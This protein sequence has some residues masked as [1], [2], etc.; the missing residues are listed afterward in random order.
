MASQKHL[1]YVHAGRIRSEV[2][3]GS[4]FMLKVDSYL[5]YKPAGGIQAFHICKRVVNRFHKSLSVVVQLPIGA[6]CHLSCS[7]EQVD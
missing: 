4:R 2:Y 1:Q 7:V 5:Q 3:S 6:K